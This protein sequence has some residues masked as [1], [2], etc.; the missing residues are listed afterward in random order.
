MILA[1]CCVMCVYKMAQPIFHLWVSLRMTILYLVVSCAPK[2]N[3][4]HQQLLHANMHKYISSV[5]SQRFRSFTLQMMS[6][7]DVFGSANSLN[8]IVHTS[9]SSRSFGGRTKSKCVYTKC[10]LWWCVLHTTVQPCNSNLIESS[11]RAN[12]E[13]LFVIWWQVLRKGELFEV[14]R[15][16]G[17]NGAISNIMHSA[18]VNPHAR[19]ANITC[20]HIYINITYIYLGIYIFWQWR[21][22]GWG[23][24]EG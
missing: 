5:S 13:I 4:P 22:E 16:L 11:E 8:R 21:A 17:F 20:V 1:V 18:H 23:G 12:R 15:T 6:F 3:I 9:F 24:Y 14:S 7:F 10:S 2:S 19:H